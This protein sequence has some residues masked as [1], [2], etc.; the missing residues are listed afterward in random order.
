MSNIEYLNLLMKNEL[1]NFQTFK[2]LL[3]NKKL[4]NYRDL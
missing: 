1:N 2:L 3:I 4:T